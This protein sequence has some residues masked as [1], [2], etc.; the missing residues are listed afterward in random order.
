MLGT[1]GEGIPALVN[2]TGN[3]KTYQV[4][5]HSFTLLGLPVAWLFLYVGYN[6]YTILVIYCVIYL[7]STFL[8][9]FL[10]RYLYHFDISQML[11]ISYARILLMSFPLV[12]VYFVYD[13]T[14]FGLWGHILGLIGAEFFLLIIVGLLGFDAK[15]RALIWGGIKNKTNLSI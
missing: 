7:L 6:Q 4:I 14:S 1:L 9:L 3:I 10:L 5:F 12:I 8:R 13:P 15:E 11:K 2:A